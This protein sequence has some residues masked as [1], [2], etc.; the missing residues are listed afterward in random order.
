MDWV[1]GDAFEQEIRDVSGFESYP[2][3]IQGADENYLTSSYPEYY[4]PSEVD[5]EAATPGTKLDAHA[6]LY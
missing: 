6:A 1:L 5:G 4:R 2:V 3:D